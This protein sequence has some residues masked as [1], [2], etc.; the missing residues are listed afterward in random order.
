MPGE[1]EKAEITTLVNWLGMRKKTNNPAVLFLGARAGGLFRSQELYN[2]LRPFSKRT[3][4]ELSQG[5]QF[6][7][8]YKVLSQGQFSERELDS[9]LTR[10][11]HD[12]TFT[13]ADV[14]LAEMVKQRLFDVIISSNIDDLLEDSFAQVEMRELFDYDVFIPERTASEEGSY[15]ERVLPCKVIK[16]FGALS[17][18]KYRILERGAY[19]DS[20]QNLK[21]RLETYLARDVLVVGL[22]PTW[23]EEILR[24]F[25]TQ[26]DFL[27]LVGEE[28]LMTNAAVSRIVRARQTKHMVG[29]EYHEVWKALYWHLH[30][31][32]PINFQLIHSINLQLQTLNRD[33][34]RLKKDTADIRNNL[35]KLLTL[36]ET[37]H[38]EQV[39][40]DKSEDLE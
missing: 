25:P 35:Q 17:S 27:W 33:L 24:M 18:K 26:G 37:R 21:S 39:A 38:D 6:E 20:N 23:D 40:H 30:G 36:V 22:D 15:H 4:S 16:A 9:I 29:S 14:C 19:L 5:H 8:C 2:I 1:A 12:I 3:L 7:E 32:M 13:D 28:E 11:L 31:E 34:Q 10:S